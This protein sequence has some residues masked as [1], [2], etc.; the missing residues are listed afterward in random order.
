[1]CYSIECVTRARDVMV[2]AN[3][4]GKTQPGRIGV[5]PADAFNRAFALQAQGDLRGAEDIYR[6]ILKQYPKHFQTLSN[7]GTVLLLGERLDEAV[8]VLRKALNQEPGSAATHAQLARA[9]GLLDRHEEALERARRAI[10]LNPELPGSYATLA[11]LLANLGRYDEAQHAL[12]RA[13]EL[14]PDQASY[15]YH[16]G[17]VKRWTADD[18]RL[19]SLE[20]LARRSA[21][22]PLSQ[23]AAL[24]FALA[25]AYGDCGDVERAFHRQ[26]EG[27]AL[28]R[29]F[30]RYDEAAT[31]GE[32]DALCRALDADWLARHEGVGDPTSLPVFVLGM[33]RSGSTL[34]EQVLASHPKVHALGER[35]IFVEALAQVFGLPSVP[36][37]LAQSVVR[38]TDSE[39]RRLGVLYREAIRREAPSGAARIIDKL[40]A[41]F[42]YIGLIHAALPM[43]AS[44]TRAATPLIPAFPCSRYCSRGLPSRTHTISENSVAII[45]RTSR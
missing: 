19:A 6:V 32:L 8:R 2:V 27:G 30:L 35:L 28:Q 5:T 18:P 29:R 26:I 42:Q 16:L 7:L 31:L 3:M 34:V 39:L 13:I 15:Y 41:N 11:Q 25:K 22:L 9:L 20:A 33:P 36:P 23:Q 40:P 44:S 45:A 38:W 12:G 10:A 1:M 4:D 24:N 37:S 14:A 17:Q 21:A 43:R